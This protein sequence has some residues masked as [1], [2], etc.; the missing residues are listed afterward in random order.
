[1]F[2][3]IQFPIETT[4]KRNMIKLRNYANYYFLATMVILE[5]FIE[6]ELNNLTQK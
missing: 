3:N 1:M 5:R 2:S 4:D 6:M